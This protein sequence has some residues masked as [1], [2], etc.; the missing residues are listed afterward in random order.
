[1]QFDT[2]QIQK[3]FYTEMP[4]L[5]MLASLS[6]TKKLRLSEHL[7]CL[8]CFSLGIYGCYV[9]TVVLSHIGEAEGHKLSNSQFSSV[10]VNDVNVLRCRKRK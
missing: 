5:I 8:F 1:M 2:L 9:V 6:N 3:G 10:Q 4:Q 7:C